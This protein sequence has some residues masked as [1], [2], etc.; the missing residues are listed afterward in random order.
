[1]YKTV[2]LLSLLVL[3]LKFELF[4]IQIAVK[5]MLDERR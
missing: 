3:T 5:Q 1:M 4:K 2:S